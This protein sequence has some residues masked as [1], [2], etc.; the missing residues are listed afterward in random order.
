MSVLYVLVPLAILMVI[1]FVW[2]YAWSTKSGQFDDLTTPA[3]RILHEDPTPR[4]GH[5]GSPPRRSPP[6]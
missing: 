1:A 5:S 4:A 6:G 3:M 2:A